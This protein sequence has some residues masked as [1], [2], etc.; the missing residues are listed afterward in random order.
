MIASSSSSND[1]IQLSTCSEF[2]PV[3]SKREDTRYLWPFEMGSLGQAV[4]SESLAWAIEE[5]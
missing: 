2:I 1:N 4:V 5:D 3:D